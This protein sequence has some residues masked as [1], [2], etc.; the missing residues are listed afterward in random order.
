MISMCL[1]LP[2]QVFPVQ[3]TMAA[4]LEMMVK[5][6]SAAH[7]ALIQFVCY[8]ENASSGCCQGGQE[9]ILTADFQSFLEAVGYMVHATG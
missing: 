3:N 9:A 2:L 4:C 6:E 5:D 1:L 8:Y 7:V